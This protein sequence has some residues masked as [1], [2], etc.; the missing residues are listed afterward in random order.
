MG[1]P[2]VATD[3]VVVGRAFERAELAAALDDARAGRGRSVLVVGEAGMGKSVLADWVVGRARE[4]GVRVVRGGCSAAGVAPL[5]PM[6]QTLGCLA[7]DWQAGDAADPPSVAGREAA[8]AAA[9]QIVAEASQR[10]P[11]LIVLEDL[12]WADVVSLLVLRAI[13][14]AVPGLAVLVLLTSRD[15]SEPIA[16]AV[17][18]QLTA[19]PTGVRRIPVPPLDAAQTATLA[20]RVV[21]RALS[22]REIDEL[23]AR[24]GGNP[25]FVHEVARLLAAH[26]AAGMLVVPPGVKDVLQRRAARLSQACAALLAVAALVAESSAEIVELGLLQGVFDAEV[27]SHTDPGCGD[28]V[29]VAALLDEAVTARLVEVDSAWP[30]R[31][32]FRHTL[33]REVMQQ[34]LPA[35]DRGGWH[36]RIARA[37]EQRRERG[38]G[39]ASS[40]LAHHWCRA[41][42]PGADE[43]AALWSLRAGRE[44]MAGFGFEE[45]AGHFV[46]AL[47]GA[48]TDRIGVSIEHGEALRLRGGIDVA[49]EVLLRAGRAAAD[50]GRPIDLAH[51]ALALG[52]GV[53]GFEVATG[54]LEQVEL[55]RRADAVLPDSEI[56]LR[57][58]VRG[59]LSLASS[60]LAADLERVQLAR[61]AARLARETGDGLIESAVLAAYCD[62][63]AGPD[64]VA[65]RVAAATRM[66]ELADGV[67]SA[68][69]RRVATLLLARRLLVVAHLEQGDLA[70]AQEQ[71]L[72]YERDTH[73]REL[74]QHAWLPE[75][76][77]GMRA[78]LDGEPD[79]ALRHSDAAELIG[80]AAGSANAELMVFTVR[81]QAHLDRG[82]AGQ[83]ADVIE[84]LLAR[85]EPAGMPAMYLAAPARTLLTAGRSDRARE[86]LRAFSADAPG[87]MPRDAEW[88]ESQWAM[89]DI[90]LALEDRRA[91]EGLFEAL[92]PYEHL[93]AVDGIGGAVFG[94]VAEQLGRLAAY[95]GRREEARGLLVA[96]RDGYLDHRVP[97]LAARVEAAIQAITDDAATR[98]SHAVPDEPI[99]GR[100]RRDGDVWVVEWR[101][102]RSLVSDT[103]GMRDLTVLLSRP[104]RAV[105]AVELVAAGGG[106][107]VAAE[108]GLGPV[109]DQTAR[110]AYRRRLRE[111]DQE[112]EDAEADADLGRTGRLRA[113]RS[114]LLDQLGAATGLHGR[115]RTA[116][117]PADRARKAVTM[118]I[119]AAV[120][121]IGR[122][123]DALARHLLNA[124][125]TGR[126]CAYEPDVPVAW[127]FR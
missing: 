108:A 16:M 97:A 106:P 81:L 96:A 38:D 66:L 11:L 25:F 28:E 61:S 113:E 64:H 6:R 105:P 74:A 116:G 127:Q 69:P 41:V 17:H 7:A 1:Q 2:P 123:D 109:L 94:R 119:R 33:V 124:V 65:D 44:A 50:A 91:A 103:K 57:A 78:L 15:D 88:L 40:R 39:V 5:W 110:T 118:R 72:A 115:V 58:A 107:P 26:G 60:G 95:L 117:D 23:R 21:G 92:R 20:S 112:I 73:R 67:S 36:T 43:R 93:W 90:A 71:A 63:I 18:E 54:D 99:T 75:I 9:V 80:Q 82:T 10:E 121:S 68:D 111:L 55:L 32:R 104:G 100:L 77:R 13:V 125:R 86:V 126:Y 29:A 59:R 89:A 51:A 98:A 37:L 102:R 85:I 30:S 24:T 14:D 31:Y 4:A 52:G 47:A 12:H 83:Y 76:W 35:S 56:G 84:T 22:E 27:G 122:H 46:R 120:K 70:A 79:R 53:A 42:G 8:A 19:L 62:A 49:R 34:E 87:S 45:A 114:M 3:A 48:E 101:G